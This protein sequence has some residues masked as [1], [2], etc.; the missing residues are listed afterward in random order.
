MKFATRQNL[1]LNR[2]PA[3]WFIRRFVDPQAEILLFPTETALADAA[4]AGAVAFHIPGAKLHMDKARGTT[5][6][7]ALIDEYGF[8]GKDPALD[9]FSDVI[10]DASY[11]IPAGAAK[12]P[13]SHG[14]KAFDKGF[15]AIAPDDRTRMEKLCV[16]Y[17]AL[18]QWCRSRTE[19]ATAAS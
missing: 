7:D 12:F 10:R 8:R 6:L 17:E 14:V 19:A 9:L 11:G 5:T 18:Y 13:E 1:G 15:R 3:I 2:P 4:K 16:L